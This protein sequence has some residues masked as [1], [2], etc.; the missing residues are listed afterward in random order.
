MDSASTVFVVDDDEAARESVM[1]LVSLQGVA[2]KGFRSA[3][4]FLAQ[5]QVADKGCLVV[6]VRMRGMSGLELLEELAGRGSALP[7]VV[8]TGY[9]DVPLAVRAMQMGAVTFLEKPCQEQ[10]LWHGIREA[11]DIENTQHLQR[12]QR[13]EVEERLAMLTEEETVIL[14]GVLQGS[15]NKRIAADMKI[16]LRTIEMRRAGIMRKMKAESLAELV[17]MAIL[18]EF[19]RPEV[20]T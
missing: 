14:R 12:K 19:L 3:E 11:L 9:G 4:D 10:A 8:I 15:Q 20:T 18:A 5:Y 13:A 7:V 17:R 16:G 1:A 6:D 2:A